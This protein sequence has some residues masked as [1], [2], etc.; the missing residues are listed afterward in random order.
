MKVLVTG[1]AGYIG[2]HTVVSLVEAGHEPVIVDNFDNSERSVIT[3]LRDMTQKE[4]ASYEGDA[5]D[6]AFLQSV[7]DA[8]HPDAVIHF[9]AY[10]AVGESVAQPL[11]YYQNNLGSLLAVLHVMKQNNCS[12]IVFSSSCTVYGQ[13]DTCP[14]TEA[15]PQKPAESPYGATKQ[16]CERILQD[17]AQAEPTA[18]TAPLRSIALRYFNPV[19]A[20]PSSRI[21]EPPLGTPNNLVPYLTQATAGLREPLTVF[22][23]DYPT[24][25]GTCI[26]DFIH[27]V[28]LAEAHVA[29]L[30][31]VDTAESGFTAVNIGTGTGRSVSE[32]IAAFQEATG[33]KVP[34]KFGPRRAGDV[35]EVWAD[36]S[37]A[38]KLLGWKASRSLADSMRDAWNWQ[39]ALK[40]RDKNSN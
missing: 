17:A 3:T 7:W 9:A 4:L 31:Y 14:V 5:A 19:G 38:E 36:A 30:T 24:P 34:Y 1:G 25:D 28:D 37:N 18:S 33:E 39:L 26:R 10:K 32:L 35:V 13:P 16:M 27:V 20:H 2:S 21:G 12:K 22:G 40:K 8:E 6:T 15:T 11:K 29:A 23:N